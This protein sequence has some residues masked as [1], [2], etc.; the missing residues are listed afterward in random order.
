[1]DN[2][3]IM[4]NPSS[5]HVD[6][7]N[8]STISSTNNNQIR[9]RRICKKIHYF[10]DRTI[11]IDQVITSTIVLSPQIHET[12]VEL[13]PSTTA[14]YTSLLMLLGVIG[15]FD[16][17]ISLVMKGLQTVGIRTLLT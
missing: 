14:G 9:R 15:R 3:I 16:F 17:E 7:T 11:I 2:T 13:P 1:M 4:K 5:N 12:F 6:T 8:T 10:Y